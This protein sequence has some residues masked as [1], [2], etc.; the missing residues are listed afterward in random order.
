VDPLTRLQLLLPSGETMTP[1]HPD[2][3]YCD[4]CAGAGLVSA[5]LNKGEVMCARCRGAGI[6]HV[7]TPEL[8]KK[9]S[10]ELKLRAVKP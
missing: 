7:V 8:A 5:L 1:P 10:A 9:I 6:L 2:T 3:V 4:E